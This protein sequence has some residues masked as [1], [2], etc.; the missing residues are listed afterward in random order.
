MTLLI[1]TDDVE[2]TL[3]ARTLKKLIY[4]EDFASIE[5]Y[6]DSCNIAKFVIII[7]RSYFTHDKGRGNTFSSTIALK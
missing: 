6:L 7:F 3:M 5:E 4:S 2:L 1:I